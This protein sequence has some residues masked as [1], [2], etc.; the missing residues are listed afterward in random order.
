[1]RRWQ[2]NEL[3]LPGMGIIEDSQC[4][5]MLGQFFPHC[6][7]LCALIQQCLCVICSAIDCLSR[8]QGTEAEQVCRQKLP[9]FWLSWHAIPCF[10]SIG[11]SWRYG[12]VSR[13]CDYRQ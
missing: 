2:E 1:M 13:G 4:A 5:Y 10:F 6:L 8:Q 3:W 9:E 11:G 7:V 12:L